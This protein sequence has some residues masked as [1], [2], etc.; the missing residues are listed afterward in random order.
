MAVVKADA[1][2]HG[3]IAV[4]QHLEPYADAFAVARVQEAIELREGGVQCP[5]TL[6]EGVVD[7]DGLRAAQDFQLDLVIHSEYQLQMVED[8]PGSRIWLKFDTGMGRLGL[9]MNSFEPVMARIKDLQV[10]G[11]MSH[12]AESDDQSSAKTTRQ[13]Q[14]FK[15]LTGASP[16]ALSLA[17]S[18]AILDHPDFGLDWVRPGIMLYGGAQRPEPDS[19][20]QT[21]GRFTAPVIANRALSK[22]DTVGYG[23]TWQANKDCRVIVVAAGYADGYPRE[24]SPGT[25]VGVAGKKRLVVGRISMDMMTVLLEAHDNVSPG[26]VVELWGNTI[27]VEEVARQSGTIAYTL[28]CGVSQRVPRIYGKE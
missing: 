27:S 10:L 13:L 22:G 19:R 1:Y 3:A 14:A 17:N 18:A 11:V 21:V 8:T 12:L 5:I 16:Y 28:M 9:P 15:A 7:A 2:G 20:L 25:Y 6:L 4:A 26:Q 24:I 23:S